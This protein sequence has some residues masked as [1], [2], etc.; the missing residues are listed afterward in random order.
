MTGGEALTPKENNLQ[1]WR[2]WENS[3]KNSYFCFTLN[4]HQRRSLGI[5]TWQR[6][7]CAGWLSAGGPGD[8]D[9]VNSSPSKAAKFPRAGKNGLNILELCFLSLGDR[10]L[11]LINQ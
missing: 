11:H 8:P 2:W 5:D 6:N 3:R 9:V 7:M 4:K 1:C 10:V